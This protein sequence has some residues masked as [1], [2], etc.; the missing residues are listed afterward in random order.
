MVVLPSQWRLEPAAQS[1]VDSLD[2]GG[3]APIHA[4]PTHVARAM[5]AKLQSGPVGR[6]NAHIENLTFPPGAGGLVRARIVRPLVGGDSLPTLM[7]FHGGGW[8]LGDV[9]T[10]DRLIREIAVGARAAVVFVEM[11]RAPEAQYPVAI[12]E[13]YGATRY[14]ADYGASHN[15]DGS[16]L[17]VAGDGTGGNVAA[18]VTLMAKERRGPK[19]IFQALL[20]PVTDSDFANDSYK[21]FRDG[22]WLTQQTMKWFWD[23]YLPDATSRMQVTA[24]PLKATVDQLRG[25]PDALIITA[26][27]DVLRDEGEAYARKLAAAGVRVT[28]TRYIGT[29]H[30]FA[31]LDALADSPPTRGAIEQITARLRTSLE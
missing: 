18:A 3:A 4:L 26:E 2:V 29:I 31:M 12:E 7:Y 19:I 17:A 9:H 13:A 22:P 16:R 14:V 5:L 25:L 6:P 21:E 11:S 28:A 27:N 20:Y 8:V 30:D 23:I 15:V 24:C 1:F 10:H